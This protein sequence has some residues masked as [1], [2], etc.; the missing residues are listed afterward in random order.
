MGSRYHGCHVGGQLGKD[1]NAAAA[2]D[3]GCKFLNQFRDLADIRTQPAF[4]HVR[5]GKVQFNGIRTVVFAHLC[6]IR[7]FL[8]VLPH[9]RGEDEFGRIIFLQP[10]EDIHI[11]SHTVIGK[12][13]DVFETENGA[14]VAGNGSKARR[15]F[16]NFKITDGLE[17]H[18]SPSGF[19]SPCT[20]IISAGNHG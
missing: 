6:Q 19:K 17:R 3:N 16:M 14:I 8:F 4:R 15:C 12:L 20:H 10:L 2:F 13:F 7:P 1:R 18:T 9:H 11:F 5:A